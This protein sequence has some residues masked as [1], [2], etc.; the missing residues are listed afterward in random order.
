MQLVSLIPDDAPACEEVSL[1]N[2]WS[3]GERR[4]RML[5]ELGEAWGLRREDGSLAG[6]AMRF[7]YGGAVAVAAMVLVRRD[8][9]GRGCGRRLMKTVLRDTPPATY[10][11]ATEQGRLL[12][13][14]LGFEAKDA[15][16]R[17]VGRYRPGEPVAAGGAKLRPVAAADFEAIVALD[18]EAF[19]ASRETVVRRLLKEAV[20]AVVAERDGRL[21]GYALALDWPRD[22]ALGPVVA[23]D[24]ALAIA[25]CDALALSI[26]AVVRLDLPARWLRLE[27]WAEAHGLQAQPA[28]PMMSLHGA[29]LPGARSRLFAVASRGLG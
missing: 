3:V 2:G 11:Y 25:L 19:G 6:C 12:Y 26:D 13:E 17:R 20:D 8:L 18:A 29:E 4:W 7:A 27:G 22:V 1:D 21:A 15:L 14:R 23:E 28:V 5:L 10:L 24:E 16:A 9:H